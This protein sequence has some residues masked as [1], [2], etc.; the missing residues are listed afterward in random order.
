[1][2][3]TANGFRQVAPPSTEWT[4]HFRTNS[5]VQVLEGPQ[6]SMEEMEAAGALKAGFDGWL[7]F[8]G[9]EERDERAYVVPAMSATIVSENCMMGD[10]ENS[11]G[12]INN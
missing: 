10:R 3:L 1:M 9:D 11:A 4:A 6:P 12:K 8:A 7:A 2:G 5:Q